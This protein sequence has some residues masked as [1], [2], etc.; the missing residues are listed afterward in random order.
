M[1]VSNSVVAILITFLS[2][3]LCSG[4]LAQKQRPC[5]NYINGEGAGELLGQ[6][7]AQGPGNGQY[8]LDKGFEWHSCDWIAYYPPVAPGAPRNPVT[9]SI[10][11]QRY[12]T[13]DEMRNGQLPW[14]PSGPK[15][16]VERIAKYGELG[17]IYTSTDRNVV[18]ITGSKGP[19]AFSVSVDMG[20]NTIRPG[21]RE[22]LE[23]VA[24]R[25]WNEL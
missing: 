16:K 17:M 10:S 24:A 12:P 14:P 20:L 15:E 4:S 8:R 3:F 13:A 25:L 7:I 2:G 9:L 6:Q 19:K 18:L 11:M 23:K 1:R 5:D 22:R 21:T